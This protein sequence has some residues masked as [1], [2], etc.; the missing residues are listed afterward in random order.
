[1]N[2]SRGPSNVLVEIGAADSHM[3]GF[4]ED[5]AVAEGGT[6]CLFY[7]HVLLAVVPRRAHHF[8]L[9]LCSKGRFWMLKNWGNWFLDWQGERWY[10]RGKKKKAEAETE[11]GVQVALFIWVPSPSL[12]ARRGRKDGGSKLFR[13]PL[14]SFH[15]LLF[16]SPAARKEDIGFLFGGA[17]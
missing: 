12:E 9:H 5:L 3:A 2:N 13:C 11:A 6:G 8:D 14:G 10:H 7:A 1:M 16:P 15:H 17:T 4:D